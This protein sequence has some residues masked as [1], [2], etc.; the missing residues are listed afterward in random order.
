MQSPQA[1]A[2]DTD[3]PLLTNHSLSV[4]FTLTLITKLPWHLRFLHPFLVLVYRIQHGCCIRL[5]I[6]R[7]CRRRLRLR[8]TARFAWCAAL[9]VQFLDLTLDEGFRL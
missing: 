1:G 7:R 6:L 3:Y 2:Y 8:H 9:L 4:F 5:R